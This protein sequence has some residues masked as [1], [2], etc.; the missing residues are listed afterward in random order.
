MRLKRNNKPKWLI[1]AV[2]VFGVLLLTGI[3]TFGQAPD[4][5][6]YQ[7]IVRD[8]FGNPLIKKEVGVKISILKNTEVK[9][10]YE[11]ID[12]TD[13][14]GYVGLMIGSSEAFD[15]IPWS[16]GV[17]YLKREFDPN[18]G[19]NYTLI[20]S[21]EILSTVFVQYANQTDS[22]IA[23]ANFL[24]LDSADIS[25]YGLT[26][27][28]EGAY[29]WDSLITLP[30]VSST[31][32]IQYLA[33]GAVDSFYWAPGIQLPSVG[34]MNSF[35]LRDSEGKLINGTVLPSVTGT[36]NNDV[37]IGTSGGGTPSTFKTPVIYSSPPTDSR[38]YLNLLNNNYTWKQYDTIVSGGLEGQ[39]YSYLGDGGFGWVN[40][41]EKVY[42]KGSNEL[43]GEI[44]YLNENGTH[45]LVMAEINQSE[46]STWFEAF[47][48]VNDYN[49]HNTKGKGFTDW[50]LP[51]HTELV[52]ISTLSTLPEGNYW[53]STQDH[54][55]A[56]NGIYKKDGSSDKEKAFKLTKFKVRAVRSF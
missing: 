48:V 35:L 8:E 32:S 17:F 6:K 11:E 18:G 38:S 9:Y 15:T 46:S 41:S 44:V 28:S 43:G 31:G 39:V 50:R 27:N 3:K 54:T 13:K 34:T 51:T 7:A 55:D 36:T 52:L 33:I 49:N 4:S 2:A 14:N 24:P 19:T 29:K 1:N 56:V 42:T 30:E 5:I 21:S 37:L 53:S 12:T 10:V 40:I 25:G 22:A 26:V 45:G 47:E 23:T 20:E 16:D